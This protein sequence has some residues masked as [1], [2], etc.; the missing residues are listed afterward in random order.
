MS[1]TIPIT[2]GGFLKA[3]D[4]STLQIV[5]PE[6]KQ[7]I[8]GIESAQS[9]IDSVAPFTH[10]HREPDIQGAYDDVTCAVFDEE[11]PFQLTCTSDC[12][13]ATLDV[14]CITKGKIAANVNIALELS[15]DQLEAHARNF[16]DAAYYL[17]QQKSKSVAA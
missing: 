15:P 9:A 13:T 7:P 11:L 2:H 3:A 6:Q 17:R 1:R 14:W 4:D 5:W 8:G 12:D 16:V 10:H